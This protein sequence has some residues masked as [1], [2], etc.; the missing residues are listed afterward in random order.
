MRVLQ[1]MRD[2]A[3]LSAHRARPRPVEAHDRRIVTFA[4]QASPSRVLSRY[5]HPEEP[6]REAPPPWHGRG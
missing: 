6:A 1:L 2:N 3:L 4:P 5:H